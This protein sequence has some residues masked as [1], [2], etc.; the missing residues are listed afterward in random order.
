[1][2]PHKPCA[3]VTGASSGIGAAVAQRLAAHGTP[4]VVSYHQDRVGA[5]ATVAR[6]VSEGGRALCAQADVADSDSVDA[7][8]RQIEAE[9]LVVHVLV[10]NA[11]IRRDGL[12]G[13]LTPEQWSEVIETDLCSAYRVSRRALG[14]M[15][16]ARG[17]R[18]INMSSVAGLR[19]SPGQTNYSAAKAGLIGL[20]RTLALEVAKRGITVNA[21]APGLIRT[22]GTADV[23]TDE[24]L[25]YVPA[26]R[27]GTPEDVAA[28]VEFLASDG[29]R[30][31]TGATLVVDGGLSA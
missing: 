15:V 29:A 17:G 23:D 20:T 16:R 11:G 22:P 30:Y 6:I 5:A 19:G 18:I 28:C 24:F 12:L 25:K 27:L 31:I 4:V 2:A 14:R 10:N 9:G 3:L 21:V 1:V 26:G 13:Q 7:L 8:F